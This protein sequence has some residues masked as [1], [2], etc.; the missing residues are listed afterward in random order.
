MVIFRAF[1]GLAAAGGAACWPLGPLPPP[2]TGAA[3]SA[4]VMVLLDLLRKVKGE[5]CCNASLPSPF[6]LLAPRCPESKIYKK[7]TILALELVQA[8]FL[9]SFFIRWESQVRKVD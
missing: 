7:D 3:A 5:C 1:R 2:T 6:P 4:M 9:K 8:L